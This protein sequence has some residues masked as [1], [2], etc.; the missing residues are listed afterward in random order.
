VVIRQTK[1]QAGP[2]CPRFGFVKTPIAKRTQDTH[3]PLA[4]PCLSVFIRGHLTS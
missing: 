4:N 2:V 3:N 1:G